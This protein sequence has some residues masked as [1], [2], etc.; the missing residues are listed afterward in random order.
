MS[1]L[2]GVV[3]T[4]I[5]AMGVRRTAAPQLPYDDS[6]A[7]VNNGGAYIET[8]F[9][10][11]GTSMRLDL[12]WLTRADD[13]Y[14][15]DV[16]VGYMNASDAKDYR[17]FFYNSSGNFYCDIGAGTNGRGSRQAETFDNDVWH[18]FSGPYAITSTT[19]LPKMDGVSFGGSLGNPITLSVA[20]FGTEATKMRFFARSPSGTSQKGAIRR[21]WVSDFTTGTV[22]A[23]FWPIKRNGIPGLLDVVSNSFYTSSEGTLDVVSWKTLSTEEGWI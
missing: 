4:R 21:A 19:A 5:M 3:P 9:V 16:F 15:G 6:L 14:T 8:D 13:G 2:W 10:L 18:W 20:G 12:I 11:G 1:I 7:L 17:M 23:D 22:L